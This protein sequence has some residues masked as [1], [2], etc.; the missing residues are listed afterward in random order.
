MS[1]SFYT[2]N[3]DLIEK[4]DARQLVS[5]LRI[6]LKNEA[7]KNGIPLGSVD[8]SDNI[9]AADGG[10]DGSIIWSSGPSHTDFLPYKYVSFQ[11]KAT[12]LPPKECAKEITANPNSIDEPPRLKT[13]V[14]EALHSGGHYILVSTKKLSA[15]MKRARLNKLRAQVELILGITQDEVLI[16]IY[17][18]DKLANWA[19]CHLPAVI[20]VREWAGTAVLSGLKSFVQWG[21]LEDIRSIRYI[22]IE[23]RKTLVDEIREKVSDPKLCFRIS[24]PAGIGK[25]RT[26][27]EIF[28]N[29]PHLQ[30][31]V[32]YAD[33]NTVQNI[34]GMVA[35]LATSGIS[36]ILVIDNCA[37][38]IHNTLMREV[39]TSNS[40]LSLLTIDY[41]KENVAQKTHHY[42]LEPIDHEEIL[43]I[44]R[45]L[46]GDSILDQHLIAQLAQGFPQMAVLIANARI[47]HD[48]TAA[49]LSDD[50]IAKKLLW[51]RGESEDTTSLEL[52]KV[53]SLFDVF[54]IESEYQNQLEFISGLANISLD[55]GYSIIQ[56]FTKK[57]IID[58]RERFGQVTPRPLAIRLAA[59]WWEDRTT[60]RIKFIINT[61]PESL[62]ESF[63]LQIEKLNYHPNV[64]NLTKQLCGPQDPFGQAKVILSSRGSRLFRSV[65]LL[66]PAAFSV[67]LHKILISMSDTAVKGI[68]GDVRRNLVW[69]LEKLCYHETAFS[70]ACSAL[71][72]LAKNES[73]TLG[74]N[75]TGVFVQLF[76]LQM[77]GTAARPNIKFEFIVEKINEKSNKGNEL[78][79]SALSSALNIEY[80]SIVR[81]AE[82][83]GS[84]AP[85]EE[86][87]PK[88]WGDAFEY[89]DRALKLLVEIA[90]ENDEIR[91]QVLDI[92][93]GSI[94]E[95]VRKGRIDSITETIHS[96]FENDPSNWLAAIDAIN[97]VNEF[98]SEKL[99][100]SAKK[101]IDSWRELL[102]P[103]PTDL[104][105]R[106]QLTV[107]TPPHKYNIKWDDTEDTDITELATFCS[108]HESL[109]RDH[110]EILHSENSSLGFQFGLALTK[111]DI[112][113]S[114]IIDESLCILRNRLDK[115]YY[116]NFTMG[117]FK[118]TYSS[119]TKLWE[120]YM[121]CIYSD[122][123]LSVFYMRFLFTG[124]V[125]SNSFCNIIELVGNKKVQLSEIPNIVHIEG[126]AEIDPSKLTKLLNKLYLH[127]E[128]S[129]WAATKIISK[130]DLNTADNHSIAV[131][132]Q[133]MFFAL[134]IHC[135][136][137][138]SHIDMHA[139][140]LV[141]DHL[142]NKNLPSIATSLSNQILDSSTKCLDHRQILQVVQETVKNIFKSHFIEVWPIFGNAILNPKGNQS[143]WLEQVFSG[144]DDDMIGHPSLLACTDANRIIE[145]C[146]SSPIE[147]A[148][149]VARCLDVFNKYYSDEQLPNKE[150]L[151][152]ES[153]TKKSPTK[154]PSKLFI[155]MLKNFG[156]NE[157]ICAQ[158]SSNLGSRSWMGSIIGVLQSDIDALN[159]LKTSKSQS[160]RNWVIK[161]ITYSL[162]EIEREKIRE[163]ENSFWGAGY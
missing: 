152:K 128:A 45:S 30:S 157:K 96:L 43:Q 41:S 97:Q 75:A 57:G 137:S 58:R 142:L 154:L 88:T 147:G 82:S 67:A 125:S 74:N 81:G 78:V 9:N 26:V 160:V 127:D 149:F 106:I 42:R 15:G 28:N 148:L 12:N 11:C 47:E 50:E 140:E 103:Q 124:K 66:N 153:L 85:L 13:K 5:L 35:D 163:K 37:N 105:A 134:P 40:K 56:N 24:G 32:I 135:E 133:D 126:F 110:L 49:E 51:S 151:T 54:G 68:R 122:V 21:E 53:C 129:A 33:L 108:N 95:L 98:D 162:A 130:L 52:L 18:A 65:S 83:Q 116:F 39:Q 100:N 59:Q 3:A 101:T 91:I 87:K 31:S 104:A 72:I 6:L 119:N 34:G 138:A 132:I 14:L 93:G 90:S 23:S 2:V 64:S 70:D 8:V 19:N 102:S 69:S 94:R 141:S 113:I 7:I 156:D 73:E 143:F 20:A 139:W 4:L 118:G 121:E 109:F 84:L 114:S 1:N 159:P 71:Y 79:L 16:D 86:W 22:E 38:E 46:H 80:G 55:Q 10:E 155:L 63:C 17:D 145:W 99:P 61:I 60:E 92:V 117:L 144:V 131:G 120:S 115:K 77:S 29:S 146:K 25:T 76:R 112:H 158:L 44:I 150:P 107:I 36:G 27:Y 111:T 161:Q 62:V 48:P 136:V 89:W 123:S